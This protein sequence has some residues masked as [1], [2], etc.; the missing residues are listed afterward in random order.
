MS[1]PVRI[2]VDI[3]GTFTDFTVM[4]DDTGEYFT[5]KTPTTPGELHS[6]LALALR[7]LQDA[8]RLVPASV[9][10]FINGTTVSLNA[11]LE[12]RGSRV[13]LIV[14]E[15]FGDILEIARLKVPDPFDLGTQR[16]EP[17]VPRMFVRE[18]R[19]RVLSSGKIHLELDAE[20]LRE[21]VTALLGEQVDSLAVTFI[22]AYVNPSHERK[23][24]EIIAEAAPGIPVSLSTDL[25][26]EIREYERTM[27]NVLNAYVG[28]L[29]R[30]YLDTLVGQL[31]QLGIHCPMMITSLNG[32]VMSLSAAGEKPVLTLNSG[33]G[34]GAVASAALASLCGIRN[35]LTFDMGGTSSDISVV[36]DGHV[37]YTREGDVGG[38]PLVL[39]MIDISCVGAGGGSVA[40][41]DNIG[42]LKVG[43]RSA[44]ARPGPACYGHEDGEP[45]VT[46]AYVLTGI[47]DPSN[48]LGGR[49][50]L[51]PELSRNALAEIGARFG[52][53][54]EQTAEGVL[55]IAT[56]SLVAEFSRIAAKR[57]IDLREFTLLPYGGAG[58][59]H[60][61]MLADELEMR[62]ILLPLHPATFCAL[63][64]LLS[65]VRCDFI[66]TVNR[67]L[68]ACSDRDMAAWFGQMSSDGAAWIRDEG[69]GISAASSVLSADMRYL[70]QSYEVAVPLSESHLAGGIQS[71]A[72]AF[73]ERHQAV[74]GQSDVNAPVE[75]INVRLT[76][77]GQTKKPINKPLRDG[78]GEKPR[79]KATRRVL[80]RGT[81][82]ELPI[83]ERSLFLAN[84]SFEGPCIIEQSDTTAFVTRGWSGSIDRFGAI[85]LT[86][87]GT[88]KS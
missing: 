7:D 68:E 20:G 40:W 59:T 33:P 69:V 24:R 88:T 49:V 27:I 25:W 64:I 28:P 56:S 15:G 42:V 81:W 8:G 52:Y 48:F 71:V 11:V 17:L 63:G 4:S 35:V 23:A 22:N 19:E 10:S 67:L 1:G 53:S 37:G 9:A 30:A 43:P 70:G 82:W 31:H 29:T 16:P 66:R 45:A 55:R 79:P 50:T 38:F 18:V 62:S 57:G 78:K 44:G 21:Q 5:Y 6:G 26:P 14:T 2:G 86:A 85:H 77:V 47:I 84:Q 72:G 75:L 51:Y 61:C 60:A 34:S 83:Y 46:D 73:H 65:D 54:A 32:G 39:P 76:M 36:E 74:Y 41:V 87:E 12:R 80:H 13:G 58:P 3:G